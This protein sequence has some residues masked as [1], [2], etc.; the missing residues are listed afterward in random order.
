[1]FE[2]TGDSNF[3]F[4]EASS[5]PQNELVIGLISSINHTGQPVV[6]YV[7][8]GTHYEKEAMITSV[9][10]A[11]YVDREAALMF[12]NGNPDSP[13]IVGVL[14]KPLDQAIETFQLQNHEPEENTEADSQDEWSVD[15]KRVVISGKE[16]VVLKCGA[17][18]ITLTKSGKILIRGK[19]LVSRSS[20]VNKILGGSV[21][22]N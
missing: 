5:K 1:M 9:V 20:G 11:S 18:S 21:Q 12:V 14:K 15:G 2:S 22:V 10:T 8:D 17:S 7:C 13:I 19:Y 16:E 4:D 6:S 3:Q